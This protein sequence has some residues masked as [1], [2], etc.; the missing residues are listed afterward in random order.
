MAVTGTG[1]FTGSLRFIRRHFREIAVIS[2]LPVLADL[3]L[4][5]CVTAIEARQSAGVLRHQR[6]LQS[7]AW[8]S[9]PQPLTELLS[10]L[11]VLWMA[12][13]LY[14]YRLR[15]EFPLGEDDFASVLTTLVY[16]VL[17]TGFLGFALLALAGT[18]AGIWAGLSAVT[19]AAGPWIGLAA[20]VILVAAPG[21]AIYLVYVTVRFNI[22]I[23][24]AAIGE[25]RP[26]FRGMWRMGRG[27]AWA[28]MGWWLLLIADA[29]LATI[30]LVFAAGA[31]PALTRLAVEFPYLLF[32]MASALLFAEAYA[33]LN[34]EKNA[35]AG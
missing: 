9:S 30:V 28:L 27:V 1:I 8:L 15:R 2:A 34:R 13:R 19:P 20:I 16:A 6:M 7:D 33:Q 21:A 3:L 17:L 29:V 23:P 22:A 35:G 4:I 14:R 26:V 18:A 11:I 5:A 24:G 10:Y 31:Q 25:R 12:V 32:N